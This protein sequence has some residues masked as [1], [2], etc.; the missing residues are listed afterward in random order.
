MASSGDEVR[1]ICVQM[2]VSVAISYIGVRSRS[3]GPAHHLS[4]LVHDD[5]VRDA[6]AAAESYYRRR[7]LNFQSIES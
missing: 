1:F 2:A 3:M 5:S 7:E 4:K 6:T